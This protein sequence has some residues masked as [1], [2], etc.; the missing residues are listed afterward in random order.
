MNKQNK[1]WK[2]LSSIKLAIS[3]LAIIALFSLIGTFI[4]QNEDPSF[5]I[6]KYGDSGYRALSNTGLTDVYSSWWFI[7]FIV[8]FSL[9]LTACLLSRFSLKSR[10]MGTLISHISILLILAGALIGMLYGQKGYVRIEQGEE[11][12]SFIDRDRR[13][14]LG[15]SLKLNNFIY[16]ENIDPKEKLLVYFGKGQEPIAGIPTEVGTE[17]EIANTGYKVKILRYLPDF[18][19]DM[20]TKE[21]ASRS[22]KANNPAIEVELKGKDGAQQRF[23]VF[24]RFPDIHQKITGDLD[25]VY[26]WANRQPKDF[27]SKVTVIKDDKEMLSKDIRVN[28]P[29]TFAGYTFFQ[30]SYDAD[31]LNWTGLKVVKD[32][33]VGVVYL[34]FGLLILGLCIRFYIS[35]FMKTRRK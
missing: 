25:F 17:S 3:L 27:I 30:S 34:G 26:Q 19:M 16:S 12:N 18:A 6:S 2:F 29:L 22:A 11:V 31:H 21:V 33:G 5:Y 4:P 24:A 1:I 15:F 35:P 20:S 10:S 32:P 23:W 8:L 9:N 7:L 13:V 14:D 28:F